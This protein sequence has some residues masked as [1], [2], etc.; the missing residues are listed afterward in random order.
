MWFTGKRKNGIWLAA[1]CKYFSFFLEASRSAH[2]L[3]HF[4][5][6]V[7]YDYLIMKKIT[8]KILSFDR[9]GICCTFNYFL[10]GE[11]KISQWVEIFGEQF[12]SKVLIVPMKHRI[13]SHKLISTLKLWHVHIH[14]YTPGNKQTVK[15]IQ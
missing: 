1:S 8:I 15:Q 3:C 11:E 2:E 9:S 13:D 14:T 10:G 5:M 6:H 12:K 4:L 7:F